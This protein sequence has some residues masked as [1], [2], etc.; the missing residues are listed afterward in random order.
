MSVSEQVTT[1]EIVLTEEEV[2]T[3]TTEGLVAEVDARPRKQYTPQT[4]EMKTEEVHAK[5]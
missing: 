2:V 3:Q 1:Q 4:K 5:K